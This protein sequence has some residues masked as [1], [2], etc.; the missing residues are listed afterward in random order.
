MSLTFH[1]KEKILNEFPVT[2]LSY[3]KNIYKKVHHTNMYLIIPKGEKGFAW[4]RQYKGKPVCI[5]M[6]IENRTKIKN[7]KIY[8]S[9]FKVDLCAQKGTIIYG[10]IFIFN[11]TLFFSIEDIY[12]FMSKNISALTPYKKI[13]FQY[14][15]LNEYLKQ[16][17]ISK[18][19]I[20]FGLPIITTDYNKAIEIFHTVVYPP[21]FIQ[22]RMMHKR[23]PYLNQ[24]IE[25]N[26]SAIFRIRCSIQTDIY[27]LYCP[28]EDDSM[29]RHGICHIPDF[30][31]S[32]MMNN[33]F[34]DIKENNNLAA[35]EESD[36]EEEFENIHP[37]KY[38]H[39][40]R[41]YNMF[42][43]YNKKFS[44]WY[45]IKIATDA[46]ITTQKTILQME[47]K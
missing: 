16:V 17:L 6:N 37:E 40:D 35:L 12:Y 15:L 22:H 24:H 46:K 30:N 38:V 45:P 41:I 7:I 32:K 47:K 26:R 25:L 18:D 14:I 43:V 34:R 11:K 44:R 31:T 19:N 5:I 36:D 2:E 33:L 29:K 4:F 10:T 21:R 23:T 42:C 28:L 9:C 1:D 39:L 8:V 3:E 13:K 20:I 27:Y